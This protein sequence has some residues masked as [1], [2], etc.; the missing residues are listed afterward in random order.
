MAAVFF[1]FTGM[2]KGVIRTN[3]TSLQ[4]D[5][6]LHPRPDIAPSFARNKARDRNCSYPPPSVQVNQF[7][8]LWMPDAVNGSQVQS[9]SFQ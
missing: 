4:S 8:P 9:I 3:G 7:R 6:R 5:I 2:R 1:N